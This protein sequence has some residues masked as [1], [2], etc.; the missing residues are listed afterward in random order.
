M[1]CECVKCLVMSR[2]RWWWWRVRRDFHTVVFARSRIH[3]RIENSRI[4]LE[5]K[6]FFS[7]C[8]W[9]IKEVKRFVAARRCPWAES[10]RWASRMLPPPM[11]SVNGY[12]CVRWVVGDTNYNNN[13]T[14]NAA[15]GLLEIFTWVSRPST[16]E[17]V[18]SIKTSLR[19]ASE[20]TRESLFHPKTQ[21]KS[22]SFAD[23]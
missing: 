20:R 22:S 21:N 11:T 18:E 3:K 6:L 2:H 14:T 23:D 9:N 1:K 8:R 16:A 17:R 15:R 12:A 10:S 4:L 13:N 5:K 19:S 7:L